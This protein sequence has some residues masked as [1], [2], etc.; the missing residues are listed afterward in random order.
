MIRTDRR[1]DTIMFDLDGTLLPMDMEE[2]T[3]GYFRFLTAKMAAFGYEPQFLIDSIWKG[4]YAMVKND[5][6]KTNEQVFWD[7]FASIYGEKAAADSVHFNDFY[8]NEFND[9]VKFCGFNELAGKIVRALKDAGYTIVLATNPL[10]PSFAQRHRIRWAGVDAENFT[11]ISSYENSHYCKPNPLYY[12]ELLQKLSLDPGKCL[13]VGNDA[14][15]DCAAEDAGI[16]VF[17]LTDCLIN[18]KDKDISGY[19]RGGFED[20]MKY[21]K[22]TV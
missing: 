14:E 11:Y 15:E 18:G 21:L 6:T 16:D 4:T 12:K 9:A 17:L 7:C 3:S 1:Y 10:F 20:L 5:G 2:F 22:L 8:D 13:M 19:P